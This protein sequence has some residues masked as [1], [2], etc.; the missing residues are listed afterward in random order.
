MQSVGEPTV[1]T[2]IYII[3][4]W[5]THQ[6][7]MAISWRTHCNNCY[8]YNN[9]VGNPRVLDGNQL[10]N[11]LQSLLYVHIIMHWATHQCW[12]AIS[13]ITHCHHSNARKLRFGCQ[14]ERIKE[15]VNYFHPLYMLHMLQLL[16]MLHMLQPL[17]MLHM[18]QPL[19]RLHM[20]KI[21]QT[22]LKILSDVSVN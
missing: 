14:L 10:D 12:M 15:R 7:L 13:W 20:L 6:C 9:A 19:Y 22:I 18:L 1:I 11:P 8:T 21:V 4:Q 16:Y 3:M 2:V 5:A 17:Y